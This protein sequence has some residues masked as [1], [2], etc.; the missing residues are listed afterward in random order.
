MAIGMIVAGMA[1]A[2]ELSNDSVS[3]AV[4]SDSSTVR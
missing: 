3:D 2:N 4:P 1:M